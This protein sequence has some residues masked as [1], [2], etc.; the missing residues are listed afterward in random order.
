MA[1]NLAHKSMITNVHIILQKRSSSGEESGGAQKRP[2]LGGIVSSVARQN[3]PTP[4]QITFS[5]SHRSDACWGWLG[6]ACETRI[7]S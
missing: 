5:I 6:L 3:Q 4:V 2:R 7:L 1:Q